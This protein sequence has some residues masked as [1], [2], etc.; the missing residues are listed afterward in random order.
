M[1][2]PSVAPVPVPAAVPSSRVVR[3]V[4]LFD[5]AL[6]RCGIGW[7]ERGVAAVALPEHSDAR[8]LARLRR[9]LPHASP[10]PPPAAMGHT[11]AEIVSLLSGSAVDLAGVHRRLCRAAV[12]LGGVPPF[13]QRVY[14]IARQ[15]APGTTSTYGEVAA[16]LGRPGSARAVGQALSQNPLPIV[17][18]CHRVVA[19]GHRLGGFSAAG[20]VSTKLALL[21]AEGA[22]APV[23]PGTV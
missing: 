18:P 2:T 15:I 7:T 22:I 16:R 13:H 23:L 4:W 10:I 1:T 14:Q 21:S 20:G 5:T 6:G 3:G 12:D 19:A 17:V 9:R 8:L 11:V